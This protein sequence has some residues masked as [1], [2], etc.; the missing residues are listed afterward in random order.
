MLGKA[1]LGWR[2]Q[3]MGLGVTMKK[4]VGVIL[5]A[6]MATGLVSAPSFAKMSEPELVE[7]SAPEFPRAAQR[8]EIEGHVVVRY[9]V[10]T[11]GEVADLEVVE[12]TPTG[13][14]EGA[15]ERAMESWRYAAS[16]EGFA[17]IER[18]FDFAFAD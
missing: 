18:R 14:F 4:L 11:D 16:A 6:T 2:A 1:R 12:S 17:G 3:S 7:A 5:A 10:T 15:V 9:N 13:I 8:R